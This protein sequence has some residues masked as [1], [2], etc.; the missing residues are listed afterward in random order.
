MKVRLSPRARHDLDSIWAFTVERWGE[1][2]AE[3][4]VRDLASAFER[5]A[6]NPQTGMD[7]SFVRAGYRRLSTRSHSIYYRIETDIIEI[8]RILHQSQD[9]DKQLL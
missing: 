1:A 7:V 2:V 9:V 4:Y 6:T 8:I 5:I 3:R